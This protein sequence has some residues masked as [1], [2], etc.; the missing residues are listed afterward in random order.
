VQ[1]RYMD[2]KL[3]VGFSYSIFPRGQALP[4]L[5]IESWRYIKDRTL[6]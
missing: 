5:P 4:D 2:G 6:S 1:I 3:E